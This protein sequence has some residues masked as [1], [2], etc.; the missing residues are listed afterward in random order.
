MTTK[1]DAE[2]ER[3]VILERRL[4][5]AEMR[6]KDFTNQWNAVRTGQ[7]QERVVYEDRITRLQESLREA[8]KK[9]EDLED[10]L[11]AAEYWVDYFWWYGVLKQPDPQ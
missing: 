6:I 11:H 5:M 1:I 2:S 8:E 9:I 3:S 10:R 7:Q 4:E